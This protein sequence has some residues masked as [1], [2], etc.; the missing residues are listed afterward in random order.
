[1]QEFSV[2]QS[3]L[4]FR[5]REAYK[6]LRTNIEF[7]GDN[8]KVI[9]IT[10]ST[11]SEGKSTVSFELAMSFAQ[12]GMKTLLIDADTIKTEVRR[13]RLNMGLLIIFQERMNL[14]M[15]YA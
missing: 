10:S 11:P 15:L 13:V 3:N 2:K 12:N 6:M 4:D 5:T 8:N 1:M 7:S 9:F 14:R